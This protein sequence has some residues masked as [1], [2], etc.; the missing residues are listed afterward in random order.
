MNNGGS[1][2]RKHANTNNFEIDNDFLNVSPVQAIEKL[3]KHYFFNTEKNS[4]KNVDSK[5]Q[6]ELEDEKNKKTEKFD[7]VIILRKSSSLDVTII[8]ELLS[9]S[10]K[11]CSLLRIHF[12]LFVDVIC[13]IPILLKSHAPS[14]IPISSHHNVVD[15][16]TLYEEIFLKIIRLENLPIFLNSFLVD[17]LHDSFEMQEYSAISAIKKLFSVF[18]F[19]FYYYFLII[20][21]FCIIS[22]FF[23][24]SL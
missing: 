7:L 19:I 10:F 22:I 13:R 12:F 2:K 6:E 3:I 16:K 24:S 9:S 11:H 4:N 14:S 21:F 17:W 18:Y 23:I 1:K 8:L 20:L 15:S 5:Q